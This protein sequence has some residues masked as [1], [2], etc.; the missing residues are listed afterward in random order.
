MGGEMEGPLAAERTMVA[1]AK[2]IVLACAGAASQKYMQ[3]LADQQEI[4]GALADLIM[5]AYAMES[6]VI[7]AEKIATTHGEKAASAAI[8]FTQ[9]Y[10]AGAMERVESAA[11]KVITA[12]AEGD[13]LR[14][15]L[16]ILRRLMKHDPV[17]TIALGQQIAQRLLET[18]KYM[19]GSPHMQTVG[20]AA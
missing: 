3:A 4:M 18:G 16:M 7:R 11:K 9:L 20:D 13:M 19:V 17:S 12:V 5:E 15:Q 1:N 8:A 6:C 14:T 2:K 10:L